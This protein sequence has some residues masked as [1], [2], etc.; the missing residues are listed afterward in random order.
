MNE[1]TIPDQHAMMAMMMVPLCI[2]GALTILIIASYW[3]IFSKANQP[4]WAAIIPFYSAIVLFKI[5]GRQWTRL[6]VYFIPI[7]NIVAMVQ[8]I[9][10]LS[11]SFGKDTGYTVG[12]IFLGVI[13]YPMLAFGSATYIGPNGAPAAA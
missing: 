7:Y 5:I 2:A 12:L 1:V 9:N 11:K 3:K 8:D 13:F 6:F 4:G 10:R